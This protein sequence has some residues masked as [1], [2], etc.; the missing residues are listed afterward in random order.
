MAHL[1]LAIYFSAIIVMFL[2]IQDAFAEAAREKNSALCYL[3][4]LWEDYKPS[5]W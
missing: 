2:P 4:F 3:N 5:A 1:F